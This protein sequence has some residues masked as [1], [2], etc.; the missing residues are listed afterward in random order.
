MTVN[1]SN[2]FT[3]TADQLPKHTHP[4]TAHT[5]DIVKH[6]HT[7]TDH[8]H[9]VPAQTITLPDHI[10]NMEH[11]H[12]IQTY[13]QDYN[14]DDDS[15][16]MTVVMD[17]DVNIGLGN[18]ALFKTIPYSL[19]SGQLFAVTTPHSDG[20]TINSNGS[21]TYNDVITTT[22]S[23]INVS[24][25]T[26]TT[27]SNTDDVKNLSTNENT[28]SGLITALSANNLATGE[29]TTNT[30]TISIIPAYYGVNWILKL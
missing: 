27:T 20:Y 19:T 16:A 9:S 25:T 15:S 6:T 5:H 18:G 11:R 7:I 24:G 21:V 1:C 22:G 23:P 29:N 12:N 26:T 3:L 30:N 2:T 8:K 17:A 28:T 4:L 14:F 10:H 13:V